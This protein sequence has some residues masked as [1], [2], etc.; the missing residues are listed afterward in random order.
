MTFFPVFLMFSCP[1]F[2]F[3][4]FFASP[5]RYAAIIIVIIVIIVLAIPS[6]SSRPVCFAWC[7]K[8]TNNNNTNN[9][10][11]FFHNLFLRLREQKGKSR[12]STSSLQKFPVTDERRKKKKKFAVMKQ[13][14]HHNLQLNLL[15]RSITCTKLLFSHRSSANISRIK[16]NKKTCHFL[17]SF[18]FQTSHK[19]TLISKAPQSTKMTCFDPIRVSRDLG[20]L[21]TGHQVILQDF[22]GLT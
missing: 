20:W 8:Q 18:V 13:I 12:E 11:P 17:V 16:R 19:A 5:D 22:S 21:A 9:R 2:V 1:F 7:I 4:I 15:K 6:P 10:L 14:H 3:L